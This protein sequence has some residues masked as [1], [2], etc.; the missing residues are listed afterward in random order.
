LWTGSTPASASTPPTTPEEGLGLETL[1]RLRWG[2]A[3]ALLVVALLVAWLLRLSLPWGWLLGVIALSVASNLGLAR[4]A[5]RRALPPPQRALAALIGLDLGLLTLVLALT[6]GPLNP[7]ALLYVVY[8]ALAAVALRLRWVAALVAAA[9]LSYGALFVLDQ[10]AMQDHAHHMQMLDLHLQGMWYAFAVTAVMVAWYIRAVRGALAARTR[11]LEAL[12]QRAARE[13][14][15]ASLA[16]LSATAAHELASP[17][18][19]IAVI[20]RELER[21]LT[22]AGADPDHIEDARLVR[23]QVDQCQVILRQISQDA[24]QSMGERLERVLVPDAL[25]ALD[26]PLQLAPALTLARVEIPPLAWSQV[27]SE[28]ARNAR[29]AAAARGLDPRLTATADV[30]AGGLRLRLEDRAGGMPPELLARATEPFFQGHARGEG[31]GLG[32][33]LARSLVERLGGRLRLESREGQGTTAQI[34]LPLHTEED[35]P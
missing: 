19:T 24:G 13:E 29:R 33:F 14:R 3:A 28:L 20:A 21:G 18:S 10:G 5:R 31:M 30:D 26:A 32:L 17:L 16:T 9:A 35:R 15:L 22:R 8:V 12:R 27:L 6:G 11:E 34:W 7:F 1:L 2:A 23:A 4:Y 25:R